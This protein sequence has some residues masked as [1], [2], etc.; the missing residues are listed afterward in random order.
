MA[1]KKQRVALARALSF[2]PDVLCLDEPISALDDDTKM[3]MYDLLLTLKNNLDITVL[4]VSHSK[5]EAKKL[6][7]TVLDVSNGRIIELNPKE[8]S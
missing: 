7:D 1:V 6:A 5:M 4:H 2:Y 8:L 3:G